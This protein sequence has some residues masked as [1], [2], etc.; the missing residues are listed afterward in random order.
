MRTTLR[1][2]IVSVALAPIACRSDAA[3]DA[4]W[5]AALDEIVAAERAFARLASDSTVQ[6]AFETWLDPAGTLFRPGPVPAGPALAVQ[7]FS[8]GQ[9]LVWEPEW[10]DASLDGNT[11]FT[12]GPWRAGWRTDA[13]PLGHGRY[14]TIWQ[15]TRAGF[16]AVLDFGTTNPELPPAAFVARPMP[17]PVPDDADAVAAV[18][19]ADTRFARLLNSTHIDSLQTFVAADAIFLR[20]GAPPRLGPASVSEAYDASLANAHWSLAGAAAAASADLAWTWGTWTAE[21]VDPAREPAGS[22]VRIWRRVD[23]SYW[24]VILDAVSGP[25]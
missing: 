15:R 3:D 18:R 25:A 16:R 17:E 4:R 24:I 23:A 11:G 7:P 10:A 1:N 19:A 13:A 14:V 8:P 12:T 9:L 6:H 21:P 20:N 2:L 5:R 22:W